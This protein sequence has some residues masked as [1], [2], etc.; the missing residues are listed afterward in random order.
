[1][2]SDTIGGYV[3]VALLAFTAGVLLASALRKYHELTLT[4]AK[5]E[6]EDDTADSVSK[7]SR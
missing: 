5:L 2:L 1:M 6:K 7:S 4:K 3:I